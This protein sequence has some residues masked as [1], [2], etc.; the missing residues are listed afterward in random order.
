MRAAEE[1]RGRGQARG[2]VTRARLVQAA[3]ELFRRQGYAGTSIGD[4]ARRAGVGVGTVYHHFADKRAVLLTLIDEWAS[5][6]EARRRTDLELE[7]FVGDDPREAIHRWLR[8]AYDRERKEPSLYVVVLGLAERDPDVRQRYHRLEQ[9]AV[10]RLR[11]FIEFGQRRGIMRSS[12]DAASAAFLMHHAIDMAA[13]QLLVREVNEPSPDRVLV[14]LAD[15]ICRY[16]L[17]EP[18]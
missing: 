5:R 6:L 14:E 13:T 3:G 7:R 15:M 1:G 18:R 12:V 17:E 4:V 10:E 9:G 2:R 16:L 11:E 8:R